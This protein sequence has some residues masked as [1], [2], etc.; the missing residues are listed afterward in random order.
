MQRV[1]VLGSSGS[2]KSTFAR[3]LAGRLGVEVIHLDAHYWLPHWVPTP[4]AEWE[5]RVAELAARDAWVMDGNYR[6]TMDLRLTRADTV[7]YLQEYRL[8]CLGRAIWRRLQYR[9]RTRPDVGPE[10]PEK[11]DWEFVRWIWRFP[12][13]NQP[14]I[15]QRL[16]AA[17]VGTRVVLLR[18]IGRQ[19][20]FLRDLPERAG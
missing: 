3:A 4:P 9:G 15:F 20:A 13:D 19:R 12:R 7:F 1:L 6:S 8:V 18:G 14:E 16:A 2:G 11:I 17:P 10:C 5:A